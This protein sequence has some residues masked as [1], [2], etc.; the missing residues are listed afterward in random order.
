MFVS[1]FALQTSNDFSNLDN[2]WEEDSYTV[3]PGINIW[4]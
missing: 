1:D 2:Q 3:T 4:S